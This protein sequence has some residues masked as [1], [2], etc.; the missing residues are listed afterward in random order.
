MLCSGRTCKP[1]GD[2][3]GEHLN[4]T[5]PLAPWVEQVCA[6]NGSLDDCHLSMCCRDPGMQCYQ[7][8]GKIAKCRA[9]CEKG[10]NPTERDS[11]PW[12]CSELGPRTPGPVPIPTT[13]RADWVD[14]ACSE[15]GTNCFKTGCCKG[16]GLRCYLQDLESG[17]AGCR[18]SCEPG[19][20]VTEE[21]PLPWN[22]TALGG[23][24][25][26]EAPEEPEA[27][28]AAGW[29]KELCAKSGE[30]CTASAC[31]AEPGQRCY[32]KDADPGTGQVLWAACKSECRTGPD[33]FDVDSNF[34]ICDPLGPVTPGEPQVFKQ[35]VADWVEHKCSGGGESC[36]KTRCC[37]EPGTQ[38]YVK[39]EGWATCKAT[40]DA[41][42]NYFDLNPD[43]WSCKELGPR[44]PGTAAEMSQPEAAWVGEK[45]SATG[46]ENCLR[47]ACCKD[48]GMQCYAKNL[49]FGHCMQSCSPTK[50]IANENGVEELWTCDEVG[51]RHPG[52]PPC[53]EDGEDCRYSKCCKSRG[54]MCFEKDEFWGECSDTCDPDSRDGWSC[55][56]LGERHYGRELGCSWAGADCGLTKLCC[57]AGMNCYMKDEYFAG[58]AKDPPEDW[59]GTWLGGPRTKS[60]IVDINGSAGSNSIQPVPG[61]S[62]GTRLYCFIVIMQGTYEEEL[63]RVMKEL[64]SSVFQC[65]E[66]DVLDGRRA[67]MEFWGSVSNSDIF[68]D[69]WKEVIGKNRFQLADWTVKVDPDAVFFPHRLQMLIVELMPPPGEPIYLKNTLRFNGF[70]GA[71]E[72][73]STAA[74]QIMAMKL[75]LCHTRPLMA[76]DP[77]APPALDSGCAA[78]NG[79]AWER[80]KRRH[81]AGQGQLGDDGVED[82]ATDDGP[83]LLDEYIIG[84]LTAP[85]GTRIETIGYGVATIKRTTGTSA[86][87]IAAVQARL[88]AQD[89]RLDALEAGR[90]SAAST[91]AAA[92][93]PGQ[94]P[95]SA[96]SGPPDP[97]GTDLQQQQ[98]GAAP[99]VVGP[100][101]RQMRGAGKNTKHVVFVA[102]F[103]GTWD[104]DEV[105]R[106]LRTELTE[107]LERQGTTEVYGA[108]FAARILRE[109]GAERGLC[110]EET[111]LRAFDAVGL[112]ATN[113]FS[114]GQPG[115][116][117]CFF[118]NRKEPRQI[119]FTLA[120][121]DWLRKTQC[122]ARFS[123][124]T[125]S[126]HLPLR[127]RCH[128]VSTIAAAEGHANY[129][130][131]DELE[132]PPRKPVARQVDNHEEYSSRICAP[133]E[134][135]F[136][137]PEPST[138]SE[139]D[140][141]N[142]TDSS[143]RRGRQ[144]ALRH[145]SE[146]AGRGFALCLVAEPNDQGAPLLE[147]RGQMTTSPRGPR[148]VGATCLSS[149]TGELSA[150][151]EALFWL[152]GQRLQPAPLARDRTRILITAD[153]AYAR[154]L[155][156]EFEATCE[157]HY[158]ASRVARKRRPD[159]ARSEDAGGTLRA[160]LQPPPAAA[161]CDR[162]GIA[163]LS[164]PATA[165]SSA[166]AAAGH[167][168]KRGRW[169][170]PQ[171][172][173]QLLQFQ[174]L[175]RAR[176]QEGDPRF[177]HLPGPAEARAFCAKQFQDPNSDAALPA[178]LR[179]LSR[180]GLEVPVDEMEWYH[181]SARFASAAF[182]CRVDR[183]VG[184]TAAEYMKA[185]MATVLD[186]RT[187]YNIEAW[188]Q[189]CL[190]RTAPE[191]A[192]FEQ[193]PQS[194]EGAGY[195]P[196][197]AALAALSGCAWL[198]G[199]RGR[200]GFAAVGGWRLN[201][202]PGQHVLVWHE[203]QW[204]RGQILTAAPD[205]VRVQVGEGCAD[206]GR[207]SPDIQPVME[208][209][210]VSLSQL[211]R[212][213]RHCEEHCKGDAGLVFDPSTGKEIP[214]E[215]APTWLIVELFVK[216]LTCQGER[217]LV[218]AMERLWPES[219][220][221]SRVT[222]FVSHAWR[223]PFHE[224][225]E[226]L[227]AMG[228]G[229][230]FWLDYLVPER[231]PEWK[232][233]GTQERS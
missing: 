62:A 142:A 80:D 95:A 49:T 111:K 45:C 105:E 6:G 178:W 163:T 17:Q 15:A 112:V 145:R 64:D 27:E 97:R 102:G 115:Q 204:R 174:A 224:V 152:L 72:V 173:P 181:I 188:P 88:R 86:R 127:P 76:S 5:G 4:L 2:H 154:D 228:G 161:C 130:P 8:V 74:S 35:E 190:G 205:A 207:C 187:R 129:E 32:V 121:R 167:A 63:L 162:A 93:R 42:S 176:A 155:M 179:I 164:A 147:T 193:S 107:T 96:A 150:I 85:A 195:S 135:G 51:L 43:P 73:F 36:E 28:R 22:C 92:Y 11:M 156:Q 125:E 20:H 117:T 29:V 141:M 24:T 153:S 183:P 9:S 185:A 131:T 47:T 101:F 75:A 18:A 19:R 21:S 78:G 79:A 30:N 99:S 221:P 211:R 83:G 46:E 84:S 89:A 67:E 231:N 143:A 52:R 223:C 222:Y 132:R 172:D 87:D 218:D 206:H 177:R 227:D 180:R 55:K 189:T 136:T 58:C 197:A 100:G 137:S 113:T 14:S 108:S 229:G 120:H 171:G 39:M 149:N 103:P 81:V 3:T 126:D 65:D 69:I 213:W 212:F 16:A 182:R 40:C 168:P 33:I 71:I 217:P 146:A 148:F 169:R 215:M 44:T 203:A 192:R 31:C 38:C 110:T 160:L 184:E 114:K 37:K 98:D 232:P 128:A 216:N 158:P 191:A 140:L 159:S 233:I 34:W 23:R 166:A 134:F 109:Y 198:A 225:L 230:V 201:L 25:P 219:G 208:D 104:Q 10:V 48:D 41:G 106:H 1:L 54:K 157:M 77:E 220:G 194:S 70:L 214:L 119:D 139:G 53:V 165:V 209:R 170:P 50:G 196:R 144:R 57:E 60:G 66:N 94:R 90:L 124:A 226:Q 175:E 138:H 59:V 123:D 186:V 26:G 210:G 13:D 200:R 151:V 68:V 133:L 56:A 91:A 118:N 122:Q 116:A 12:T 202:G 82:A 61:Q 7:Q 199:W